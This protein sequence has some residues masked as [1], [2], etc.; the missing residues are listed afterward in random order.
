MPVWRNVA[1]RRESPLRQLGRSCGAG[2][3]RELGLDSKGAPYNAP[4]GGRR[5]RQSLMRRR[6]DAVRPIGTCSLADEGRMPLMAAYLQKRQDLL[7]YFTLRLK[8]H[9][10]AEDVVQD[11]YVRLATAEVD[12]VENPAAYLYRLGTN[13][14]LDRLK[15]R[16][17]AEARDEA[18]HESA[19]VR[20]GETPASD[21]PAADDAAASRQRLRQL[22]AALDQLPPQRRRA[23]VLHKLEGR[24]H[25]ET[26]AAMGVSRSAVEKHI[27]AAMQQLMSLLGPEALG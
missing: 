14:M 8:S 12:A 19:F 2:D 21:E 25:A 13:L 20:V 7:R 27:I 6:L 17:R 4:Q 16:R 23:F 11:I 24:S 18:W 26:A 22:L 9:A 5:A 1:G 10:L 3:R 15:Q